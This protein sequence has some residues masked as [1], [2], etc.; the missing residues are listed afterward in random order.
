MQLYKW[1]YPSKQ[2]VDYGTAAIAGQ[3]NLT[4]TKNADAGGEVSASSTYAS[5]TNVTIQ[6]I[7]NAGYHFIGWEGDVVSSD[8]AVSFVIDKNVSVQAIFLT[9]AELSSLLGGTLGN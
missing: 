7:P 4:V 8:A 3:Y 5:G 1:D 9:D 6:A 2:W